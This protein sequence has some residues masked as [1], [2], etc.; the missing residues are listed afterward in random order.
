MR[1]AKAGGHRVAV[2]PDVAD[3]AKASQRR[4]ASE[5]ASAA[6][7][8]VAKANA[9]TMGRSEPASSG[10][11][12]KMS[13]PFY[14]NSAMPQDASR[15]IWIDMEMTGLKPDGDRIIEIALVVTDGELV[16]VAEA[17]VWVVRQSRRRARPAWTRGTRERTA[18][19][20]SSTR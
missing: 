3:V 16:T 6:T 18:A 10:E 11:C 15:L 2:R 12:A 7:N 17:P 19:R 13:N 4:N 8:R 1:S 5:S 14:A 9:V 20:G